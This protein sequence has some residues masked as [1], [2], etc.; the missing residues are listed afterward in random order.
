MRNG[1]YTGNG[2]MQA[3][4]RDGNAPPIRDLN[5]WLFGR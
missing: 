5:I 3:A 4:K 1:K 2:D